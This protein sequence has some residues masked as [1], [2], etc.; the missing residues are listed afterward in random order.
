MKVKKLRH[1]ATEDGWYWWRLTPKDKW[2]PRLFRYNEEVG[3]MVIVGIEQ[4]PTR[5]A[6]EG[7]LKSST[8]LTE[9]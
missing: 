7:M 6:K 2:E 3:R 5:D 4:R 8:P 1:E 9:N